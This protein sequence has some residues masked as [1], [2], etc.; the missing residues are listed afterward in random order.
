[1]REVK[2]T[3]ALYR[4]L[5][6]ILERLPLLVTFPCTERQKPCQTVVNLDKNPIHSLCG[7][8]FIFRK[9]LKET[10]LCMSLCRPLL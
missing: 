7:G 2:V 5:K 8:A 1:M 10:L 3:K 6:I 9:E 4:F